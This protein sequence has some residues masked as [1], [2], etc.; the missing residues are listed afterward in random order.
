MITTYLGLSIRIWVYAGDPD[1][2]GATIP[3]TLS[4]GQEV[5]M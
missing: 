2:G 1:S 3:T 4:N 5:L